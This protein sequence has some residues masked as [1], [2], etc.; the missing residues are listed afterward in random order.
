MRRI[1]LSLLVG[2]TALAATLAFEPRASAHEARTV[3]GYHWL[4]G[5]GSEP[6][7]AGFENFVQLFLTDPGGKP[8]LNIGNKLHVAVQT[9]SAS[10]SFSLVPSFDPDSGLGTKG[11]FDAF[12]IPTTPGPYTFHF[13]GTLGGKVD[14]SFTSGPQTFDTVHDPSSIQFPTQV[15]TTLEVSQKVDRE[16]PRLTAAIA[17]AQTNA[18]RHAD[19]KANSALIVAIVGAVLGLVGL[20]FGVAANRKRA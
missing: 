7:Y 4:V 14:Q 9:G 10:K 20:G 11:E 13:T 15:P 17:A 19:G 18:E 1:T 16:I 2:A 12:F 5:F 3:N 6:T 8:V